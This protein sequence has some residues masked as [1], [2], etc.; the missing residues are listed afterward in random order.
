MHE[1]QF[2]P[3]PATM[4]SREFAETSIRSVG[5]VRGTRARSRRSQPGRA[6]LAVAPIRS[7]YS[8]VARATAALVSV[9]IAA[10]SATRGLARLS[11][12]WP[13]GVGRQPVPART[14]SCAPSACSMRRS[15]VL[16]EGCAT[17]SSRAALC[18]LPV[19]AMAHRA[20]KCLTSSSMP[21][22]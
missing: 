8:S 17:P 4:R 18:R 2:E 12:A 10:S 13:S 3:P 1:G 5:S 11:T 19:S 16:N 9:T 22:G 7:V 20:R 6:R 14:K 21:E 15:W